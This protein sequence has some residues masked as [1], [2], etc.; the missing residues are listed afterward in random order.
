MIRWLA[1]AL[2]WTVAGCTVDTELG[3]AAEI[4]SAA[5]SVSGTGDTSVVSASVPTRFRV[6]EHAEGRRMFVLQRAE[7]TVGGTPA[8]QM[9][10]D[11]PA[12]FTGQLDPGDD[13]TVTLTGSTMPGAFPDAPGLLCGASPVHVIVRWQD[14]TPGM[15]PLLGDYGLAE[16]ETTDVTCD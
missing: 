10:I 4:Q 13:Q 8:A 1:L 15:M 12:G 7:L 5:V 9:G 2:T 14:V 6:G 3:V 11:Y 16:V